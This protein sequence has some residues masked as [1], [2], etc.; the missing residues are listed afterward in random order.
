MYIHHWFKGIS[1]VHLF[2]YLFPYYVMH[3]NFCL[4]PDAPA[5]RESNMRVM[6]MRSDVLNQ[7]QYRMRTLKAP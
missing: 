7:I 3:F 1:L 6:K 2:L 5:G 4:W